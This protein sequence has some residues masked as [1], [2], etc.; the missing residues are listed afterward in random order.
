[1]S[2]SYAQG[3]GTKSVTYTASNMANLVALIRQLQQ[4]LEV[5]CKARAP[6]RFIYGPPRPVANSAEENS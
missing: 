2:Y 6:V 3:D 5:I 1:M 4:A